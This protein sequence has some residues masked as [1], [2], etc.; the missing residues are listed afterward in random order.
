VKFHH[1]FSYTTS[2]EQAE[3]GIGLLT[4][5]TDMTRKELLERAE[6]LDREI[7]L[8][9][10]SHADVVGYGIDIPLRYTECFA[11]L[12]DGSKV[13]FRNRRQ[14]VGWSGD[15]SRRSFLFQKGH[16]RFVI[17]APGITEQ[18]R[19]R[20][21]VARDGS[22]MYLRQW[23]Q[24]SNRSVESRMPLHALLSFGMEPLGTGAMA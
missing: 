3:T 16:R 11:R 9:G 12:A 22:L 18:R 19:T 15:E 13:R 20:K 14:F 17:E 6:I 2:P 8:K 24:E 4:T 7:P 1:I 21:F 23:R 5:E 10:A